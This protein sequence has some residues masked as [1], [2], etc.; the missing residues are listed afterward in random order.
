MSTAS[1]VLPFAVPAKERVKLFTP[2]MELAALLFLTEAK[3]KKRGLFE[4][5]SKKTSL[6][7]KLHY[8][9]W[10]VPWGNESLVVDG[11]GALSSTI[12]F[13]VLPDFTVFVGDIERG[14]SVR[15]QFRSA[16]EKH[17]KTFGDFA[18]ISEVQIN[19]LIIDR[20]LLSTVFEYVKETLSQGLEDS[21]AVVLAPPRLDHQA[22]VESAKLVSN[23]YKQIQSEMKSL[24]YARDLL[25]EAAKSH[26]Q[27]ILKEIE[28]TREAYENE[29]S[30]F[31]PAVDKKVD[32]LIKERDARIA[33]MNRI[34]ESELRAKEREK[35][36]RERELQRLELTRDDYLKRRET[37]KR[38]HDEIGVTR[39]EHSIRI[40]ENRIHE[41]KARIRVLSELIEKTRKQH[42]DDTDKLRYGYQAL[43]DG[44]KRKTVEIEF[45]RDKRIEAK[46]TEI[47]TLKHATARIMNQIEEL[48]QRKREQGEEL[49][50]L[51]MPWHFEDVTLICLPFYLVCYQ[52]EK[53]TQFEVFPPFKVMSSDGIVKTLQKT[54][55]GLRPGSRVKLLLQPRSKSVS[56]ML[57]FVFE[58][59]MKS[60]KAFND[61]LL[62][63]AAS[64]NILDRQDFKETLMKGVEE[65]RTEGWVS[66]GQGD[67][68][69][70]AYA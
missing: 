32:Q 22:A 59:K 14:A 33:K 61:S 30:R 60:D 35:E 18:K 44:E 69:I 7:S 28:L 58:E 11:L 27:M 21:S 40:H 50:K 20:E 29:V 66:E 26:E 8:P 1:L 25:N 54:L 10:A 13:H 63:A 42:E 45:E 52:A 41:V 68:L 38:R 48:T 65:L 6:V 70:K 17:E 23:L 16:L 37:R 4:A 62:R 56:K 15:E 64:A 31:R 43:I 47:E 5:T 51:T 46:E 24:E 19:A 57:D 2:S 12:P 55:R 36:R 39:W 53:K 49:K 9:L 3:R 67:A 34:M